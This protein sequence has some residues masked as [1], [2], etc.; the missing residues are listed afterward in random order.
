MPS[1]RDVVETYLRAKDENRPWL[2]AQA[3]AADA[4]LE[5]VVNT[6]TIAFPPVSDGLAALTD[7][8]VRRFAQ[9]Y[10]N[11]RTFCLAAPPP[12][13]AA[14]FT[15]DWLVGMSEKDGGKVRV[16]CGRYGWRFQ[17]QGLAERLTITIARME[18][19]DP[20]CLEPVM[21]WLSRLPYPWCAAPEALTGAPGTADLR[22][23]LDQIAA[24]R[25]RA[26][27]RTP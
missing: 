20:A 23:V 11:V 14:A 7:V 13:N 5:M 1:N 17:P 15:C 21:Q 16:G 19:L 18:S 25:S 12:D 2:M 6:E 26:Q 3:F 9:T 27:A 8:L 22:P 10:E 24:K 4:V